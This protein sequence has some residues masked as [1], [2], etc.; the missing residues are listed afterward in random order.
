MNINMQKYMFEEESVVPHAV[1][2]VY[3]R[4]GTVLEWQ[5]TLT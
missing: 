4:I 2:V 3:E 1:K 5:E